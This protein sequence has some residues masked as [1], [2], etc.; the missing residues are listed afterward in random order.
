MDESGIHEGAPV[1]A[2]AGYI[3]RPKHWRAWTKDWNQA[4]RPIKVYHATDCANFRG[5]FEGRDKARRDAFVAN[6]LPI[7]PRHELA[8]I[9]IGINMNAFRQELA[10][11][12]ELKRMLGEPYSACFQWAIS[13]IIDIAGSHGNGE[14]MA[15]VHENNNYQ[16]EALKAFNYVNE[17]LNPR[18]IKMTMR[19]GAKQEFP[20][21]QAADVLA[22][23]GAKF[24]RNP[25]GSLRR[26]W[27]ALNPDKSLIIVRRYGPDNIGTLAKT[28][29]DYRQRLL[30]QGWDGKLIA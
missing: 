3:S 17:N 14:L 7:I 15:F 26:A 18:G 27:V 8:G 9:L 23:E 16:S 20:Q 1:V 12:P 25:T 5:E 19:F 29:K 13:I 4:K 6:L 2:V 11:H 21:L 24:L 30:A 22:Y 10:D 28:L